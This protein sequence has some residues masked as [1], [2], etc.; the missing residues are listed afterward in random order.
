MPLQRGEQPEKETSA[1]CLLVQGTSVMAL[2]GG[3]SSR[4]GLAAVAQQLLQTPAGAF[5]LARWHVIAPTRHQPLPSALQRLQL[6][7]L[8]SGHSGCSQPTH[9]ATT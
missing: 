2:M 9:C 5:V 6:P 3:V 8:R 7:L 4:V 1:V